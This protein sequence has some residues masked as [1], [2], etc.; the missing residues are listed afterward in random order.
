MATR[1]VTTCDHC[2]ADV[3]PPHMIEIQHTDTVG[4]I[5]SRGLYAFCAA[6]VREFCDDI[7]KSW[8]EGGEGFA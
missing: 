7:V 8:I 6:C 2:G 5:H 4:I 3:S 1:I